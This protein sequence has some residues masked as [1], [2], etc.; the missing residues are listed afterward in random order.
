MTRPEAE[1]NSGKVCIVNGRGD[2]MMDRSQGQY[3]GKRV[4]IKRVTKGGMV[5]CIGGDGE[6]VKL[7]PKNLDIEPKP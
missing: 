3:V 1:S 4:T 6:E 5:I 7:P 2:L